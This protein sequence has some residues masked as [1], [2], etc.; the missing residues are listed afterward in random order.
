M[1]SGGDDRT[2][3]KDNDTIEIYEPAYLHKGGERPAIQGAPAAVDYD[4]GLSVSTSGPTAKRA[5]LMA[6]AA[7]TH[8]FDSNQRHVELRVTPRAG[9]LD[10]VAPPNANVAPPGYYMLFVLDDRG[11][12]SVAKWVRLGN[13]ISAS[14][15]GGPTGGAPAPAAAPP[16]SS[17]SPTAGVG[18]RVAR[19]GR[20]R[21]A[22]RTGLRVSV[23]CP[24]G[25]LATSSLRLDTRTARRLRHSS[26]VAMR[27]VRLRG[28]GTARIVLRPDAGLRGPL[29]RLRRL[30]V[31]VDTTVKL[32]GGGTRR[33]KRTLL[34]KR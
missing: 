33:I 13:W 22:L 31:T 28:A 14:S 8:G 23:I 16:G 9:G 18:V 17:A 3:Q 12:P 6:P 11:V 34:L 7:T 15:G 10:A 26:L 2:G 21:T 25:C 1:L 19:P 27:R 30:S 5:V 29:G 20:L 32:D 24:K 4:Q